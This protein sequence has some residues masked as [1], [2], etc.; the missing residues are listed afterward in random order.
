MNSSAYFYHKSLHKIIG[1]YDVDDHYSL[2][3]DFIIRAFQNAN[4]IYCD[5]IWGH[6]RYLPGTK[7]YEDDMSGNNPLRLKKL[8]S[9]YIKRL[10]LA[11][12]IHILWKRDSKRLLNRI[13]N[14]IKKLYE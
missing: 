10:P 2:D 13:K 7:T 4:I 6:H 9:S 3:V 8:T 1:P 14:R 12:R 11:D 5:E